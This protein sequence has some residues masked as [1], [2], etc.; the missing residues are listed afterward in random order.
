MEIDLPLL[1]DKAKSGDSKSL[2]TLLSLY[3]KP[4]LHTIDRL[5]RNKEDAEDILIITLQKAFLSF[6]KFENT[7]SF[8]TWLFKIGSNTAI[9]FLRRK[10]NLHQSVNK[11]SH[12]DIDILHSQASSYDNPQETYERKQKVSIMKMLINK[13]PEDDRQ[14][15]LWRY[16][17][18]LT[19]EEIASR[20]QMPIGTI[21]A[22]L[23]RVR[24]L[25][26]RW[27]EKAFKDL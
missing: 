21:K 12:H 15:I 8:S 6:D 9:D 3:R 18:E 7:H 16:N 10:N 22:R 20:L 11:D 2:N 14:L 5:V 25:L 1:I 4:L 13:L 23:F 24:K 27:I 26:L 17:D 19:Y